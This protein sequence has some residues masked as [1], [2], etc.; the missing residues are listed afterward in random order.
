MDESYNYHE[1]KKKERYNFHDSLT[2]SEI[3]LLEE[4]QRHVDRM[5]SEFSEPR[6]PYLWMKMVEQEEVFV[7]WTWGR[8]AKPFFRLSR[9]ELDELGD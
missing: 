3:V 6:A 9:R 2:E 5:I 1:G 8:T 4:K 7:L